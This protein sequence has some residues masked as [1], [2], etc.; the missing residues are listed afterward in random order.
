MSFL[1]SYHAIQERIL[2]ACQRSQRQRETVQL[3][4][5]SKGQPLWKVQ[6]LYEQT[7]QVHFGENR[8]PSAQERIRSARVFEQ[9]ER[10]L[11]W[12]FIG[13][14]QSRK[15]KYFAGNDYALL[16][17]LDNLALGE[18]LASAH[19]T[20][21]ALPVLL[22]CNVSGEA[23]KGGFSLHDWHN[24]P[25]VY[26]PFLHET[27]RLLDFPQLQVQGLM[28]MAPLDAERATISAVFGSLARLRDDLARRFPACSWQQ[29]S[30]G[31][32]DD[33]EIAIA[34]GAT[35]VRIGSAIFAD[36]A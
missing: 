14:V 5:V 25:S 17:S 35:L 34:C 6:A 7:E 18:K 20:Q 23:S 13:H 32:S 27:A 2:L 28:C 36:E 8:F 4:A 15:A 29:L 10:P 30:M 22:E 9:A 24:S 26:Q 31:M 19:Q 1:D 21:V 11:Q 16:H 33:F 12:H 3:V